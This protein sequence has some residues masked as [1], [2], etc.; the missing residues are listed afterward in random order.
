MRVAQLLLGL[1]V[2]R[3]DIELQRMRE[4]DDDRDQCE[5]AR[6]A[7][8]DATCVFAQLSSPANSSKL[9]GLQI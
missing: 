4:I 3:H 8:Y 7:I 1:D 5:S 2:F 6:P 9:T